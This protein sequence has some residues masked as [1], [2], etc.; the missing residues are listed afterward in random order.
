M[1]NAVANLIGAFP[2]VVWGMALAA[3]ILSAALLTRYNSSILETDLSNLRNKDSLEHGSAFLSRYLDEIFQRYLSP[4]VILPHN[5]TDARKV[6]A[7]L[8]EKKAQEGATSLIA[9][10]QTLDDFTPTNQKEKIQ[11]LHQ[12]KALLP[13]KIYFRMPKD[14]QNDTKA[15]LT[16]EVFK[17]LESEELHIFFFPSSPKKTAL[18]EISFSSSRPSE[19]RFETEIAC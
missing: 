12:I 19:T 1:A 15:F 11:I 9:S 3:T 17:P 8:K 10:V 16:P 2:R 14:E 6:A 13:P 18:L 5:R 7:V 4:L